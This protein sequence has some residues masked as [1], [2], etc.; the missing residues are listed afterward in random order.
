MTWDEVPKS[1]PARF[2]LET[3]GGR[4]AEVGDLTAGMWRRK[5]SLLPRLEAFGLKPV[6]SR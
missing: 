1:D 3:M 4:I 2:T 6:G 5:V